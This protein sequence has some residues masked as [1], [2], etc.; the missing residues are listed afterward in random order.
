MLP[1]IETLGANQTVVIT[2]DEG[3]CFFSYDRFIAQKKDGVLYVTDFWDYSATTLKY[4]KEAF[5]LG[6][7]KKEIQQMIDMGEI[8]KM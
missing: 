1:Q 8:K 7:T 5:R 4:F 3:K 2:I 6:L